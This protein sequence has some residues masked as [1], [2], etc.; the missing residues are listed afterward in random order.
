[1]ADIRNRTLTLADC[2]FDWVFHGY[3]AAFEGKATFSDIDGVVYHNGHFLFV[4]HKSMKEEDE[5]PVLS[6]GQLKVYEALSKM[7]NTTCWFIAGNM[8]ESVPYYIQGIGNELSA[9]L[10]GVDK[11]FARAFLRGMLEAWYKKA[12]K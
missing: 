3:D 4:E 12:S 10:R 11:I 7:P 2:R 5:P 8:Q 9:D 6:K 1:M